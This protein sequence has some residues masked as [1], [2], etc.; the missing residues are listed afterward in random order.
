M[1]LDPDQAGE[2]GARL[3]RVEGQVRGLQKMLEDGR[4]CSDVV[5]QFAA[6]IRALQ[7]AGYKYFAATLAECALDPE[8][9]A[10]EGYSVEELEAMFLRLT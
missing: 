6:A 10:A 3:R 9:A 1:R 2:I 7:R 8:T 5:T 4:E